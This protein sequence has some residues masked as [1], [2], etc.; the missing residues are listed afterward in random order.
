MEFAAKS[1]VKRVRWAMASPS[2]NSNTNAFP[3]DRMKQA[4]SSIE[5]IWQC[6]KEFSLE[7]HM[8]CTV[9]KCLLPDAM[10][11][12]FEKIWP[13][14]L[15]SSNCGYPLDLLPGLII[16]SCFGVG[17]AVAYNLRDFTSRGELVRRLDEE[18]GRFRWY[19]TARRCKKCEL[20][21]EQK[22]Q[23]G[24]LGYDSNLQAR[25]EAY[26]RHRNR[27]RK[28]LKLISEA[29]IAKAKAELSLIEDDTDDY[30]ILSLRAYVYARSNMIENAR[31]NLERVDAAYQMQPLFLL[32][33]SHILE[34]EGDEFGARNCIKELSQAAQKNA[35]EAELIGNNLVMA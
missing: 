2:L 7:P 24:C 32:A 30:L 33:L 17:G 15:R 12:R 27:V 34:L 18:L 5:E 31:A 29:Q 4:R 26:S 35:W 16:W 13:G 20:R 21:I 28:I 25:C 1:G 10:Y 6:C 22:C 14:S 8:D 23:G 19:S 9:P 3:F 11:G